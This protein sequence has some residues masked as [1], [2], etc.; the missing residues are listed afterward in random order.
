MAPATD[1]R[2][3]ALR[4]PP[5]PEFWDAVQAAWADGDAV[6]PLPATGPEPELAA[7]LAELRPHRLVD[8]S[9]AVDLDDPLVVAPGVA[10][11]S[12][13][14]GTTGP[15]KGVEIT[16][17]ALEASARA[18]DERLGRTPGDRWLCCLPVSHIAGFQVLVR[19]HLWG[20][21][22][23]VHTRF[24]PD[25][26][27]REND[28][29]LV[30]LVPTMMARLLDAGVDV[31][32]F[33]VILVGG[34][35]VP[36]QLLRRAADAGANIVRSYGMT[37]TCG[38]CVYDGIPLGGVK[39]SIDSGRV[40]IRG[41]MLARGYRG[42]PDLTGQAFRDGWFC[43]GDVGEIGGDGRLRVLGRADGVIVTGGEKVSPAEVAGAL[44]EH[45]RVAEVQVFGRPDP[46]WGERVVAV[47]APAAGA[48]PPTLEQIRSF[49]A[50]RLA[51]HKL[52]KE[53]IV[54]DP[55]GPAEGTT[56]RNREPA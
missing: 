23:A 38:G 10:L 29:T 26:I 31:A 47:V 55:A 27:A 34:A 51:P 30:S 15:P 35:A 1:P 48:A 2:L 6:L 9:G 24:D 36:R 44:L 28:V 8:A 22:A 40:C 11:V 20:V 14:S 37:E 33:R 52:P 43:S 17:A 46:E 49:L 18:S 42:R 16:P 32:R 4:L 3:V 5:G 12:A 53:L 25:A 19:S 41:P 54:A 39:V 13:T 21:P 7:L 56:A 50:G 45:V